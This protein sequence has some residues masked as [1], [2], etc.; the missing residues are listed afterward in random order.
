[1]GRCYPS[2]HGSGASRIS[3]TLGPAGTTVAACRIEI[4]GVI[5]V[6]TAESQAV[7]DGLR[8]AERAGCNRMYVETDSMDVIAAFEMRIY[9][10]RTREKKT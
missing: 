4:E 5:D 7:R 6:T 8:L 10:I 3:G 2:L 9:V 1:M